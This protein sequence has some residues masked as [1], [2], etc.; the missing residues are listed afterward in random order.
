MTLTLFLHDLGSRHLSQGDHQSL[1]EGGQIHLEAQNYHQEGQE[2]VQNC[3][4]EG[5]EGGRVGLEE[6]YQ[7]Q[8]GEASQ[9]SGEGEYHQLGE[10]ASRQ[11]E[12]E[13]LS[14][15]VA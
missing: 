2:G 12:E 11:Q 4:R 8:E 14:Q 10:G 7:Q 13:A 15:E 3:P 6:A 1:L 5:Q 9:Q